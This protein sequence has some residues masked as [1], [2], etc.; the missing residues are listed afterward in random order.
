[1]GIEN[2]TASLKPRSAHSEGALGRLRELWGEV[3]RTE[4]RGM[5]LVTYSLKCEPGAAEDTE[6]GGTLSPALEL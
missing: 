2:T 3:G 6:A 4:H 5:S 1:M